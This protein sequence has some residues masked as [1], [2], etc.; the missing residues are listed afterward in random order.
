MS[1]TPAS[2]LKPLSAKVE[3]QDFAYH[4]ESMR[5][6]TAFFMYA[7]WYGLLVETQNFASHE[8]PIANPIHHKIP[9]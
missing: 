3:T 8:Q 2:T 1:G 5:L 7:Y 4:S 9:I 6:L